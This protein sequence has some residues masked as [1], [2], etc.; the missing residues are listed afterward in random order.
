MD[1]ENLAAAHAV[2]RLEDHVALFVDEMLD[3]RHVAADQRRWRIV[4]EFHQ[5]QLLGM[6]AQCPRPV[7][8]THPVGL[9]SFE[10]P[11][12]RQVLEIEGRILAHEDRVEGLERQPFPA[13][14]PVPVVVVRPQVEV[15]RLAKDTTGVPGLR[16][17]PTEAGGVDSE[18]LV[19]VLFGG[20][21]HGDR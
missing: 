8:N 17:A 18:N 1:A 21:H 3:L 15:Q 16:L 11:G 19:A 10:Q 20:T 7:E 14:L 13:R 6:L 5:R 12:G 9:G 4:G 2:E